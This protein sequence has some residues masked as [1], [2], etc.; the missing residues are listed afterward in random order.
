MGWKLSI[1]RVL[2]KQR[3]TAKLLGM[4]RLGKSTSQ[5]GRVGWFD[6]HY[7]GSSIDAEGNPI[8]WITYPSFAFI[9]QLH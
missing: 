9:F 8:L 3:L 1:G 4:Y 2:R 5:L 6:S 7:R